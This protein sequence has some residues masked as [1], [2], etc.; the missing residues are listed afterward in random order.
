VSK[1]TRRADGASVEPVTESDA[2]LLA[3][4]RQGEQRACKALFELHGRQVFRVCVRV[5]RDETLAED[6]VQNTFVQAFRRLDSFDGRASFGAWLR[7]IAIHCSVELL[8][9]NNARSFEPLDAAELEPQTE[10]ALSTSFEARHASELRGHVQLALSS[11]TTLERLAFVLKHVEQQSLEEI[12][13][14]AGSNSN[15]IKQALF[16]GV[17]KLR[18]SLAPLK[19]E[20][21]S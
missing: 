3:K 8:R 11:L 7:T 19:E 5:L 16:R 4:A 6:A 2:R 1:L 9:K 14:V 12:A 15:A 20:L 21:Q 13:T 18:A 10:P 17:R